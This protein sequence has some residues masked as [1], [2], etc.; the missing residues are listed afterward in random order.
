MT[1]A[2]GSIGPSG[3][4]GLAGTAIDQADTGVGAAEV[5]PEHAAGLLPTMKP[6]PARAERQRVV[7]EPAE[8]SDDN[9]TGPNDDGSPPSGSPALDMAAWA[10]SMAGLFE[11][12]VHAPMDRMPGDGAPIR[13][14]DWRRKRR[15]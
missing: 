8:V 9:S 15:C 7:Q 2:I 14:V 10:P 13:R 5:R 1:T 4:A 6:P 12:A 11:R 3:T